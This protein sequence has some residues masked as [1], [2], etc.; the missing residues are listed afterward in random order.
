ME[1]RS[2]SQIQSVEIRAA[3]VAKILD[4]ML[5]KR[6]LSGEEIFYLMWLGEWGFYLNWHINKFG[7]FSF[8]KKTTFS[9]YVRIRV[10]MKF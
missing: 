10:I 7:G 1:K 8:Y 9:R 2:S 6:T 5:A 4:V 3:L